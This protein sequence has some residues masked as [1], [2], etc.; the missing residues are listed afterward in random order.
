[1]SG[2]FNDSKTFVDMPLKQEPNVILSK[3]STLLSNT[4]ANGG[5]SK[6][7]LSNFLDEY[8]YPAGYEVQQVQPVDWVPNPP[9]IHEL[10]D[11]RL[12]H[13]AKSIHDKWL[14]LARIF[15][16]S[17][18]CDDCYSS[19]SVP[20][21]F[22]IAGSRFREFYYWDSYWILRGLLV[23]DMTLTARG[24]I[25]NMLGLV[26]KYGFMPN[27]G[28]IYYL[29]RSQPPLLVQMVLEFWEATKDVEFLREV[30][31]I[32]DSE[33]QWWMQNRSVSI[34]NPNQPTTTYT[35][36]RY[37]VDN[38]GPRPES[39][40]EDYSMAQSAFP[41][42]TAEQIF[43]Y[44]SIAS[45][46]ES[47]MD[48]STRWFKP[49]S[50][51]LSTIE[52][53]DIVPVCLNSILFRNE[54]VLEEFH[55][56]L[57]NKEQS[58]YYRK[59]AVLRA[60]ALEVLFWDESTL[61]FLDYHIPSQSLTPPRFYP[62]NF[63][64]FYSKMLNHSSFSMNTNQID[65]MLQS[66]YPVVMGFVG[67]VPTSSIPSGQQWDFPNAWPPHQYFIIETLVNLN[68]EMSSSMSQDL[69]NRWVLTSYC[70]W[71]S[72]LNT[73][74]GMMFE[75]YNVTNIGVPGGGGEY[76]VQDGFG[77]S[78]G[79]GPKSSIE[80]AKELNVDSGY[81]Y[82]ILRV[83]SSTLPY[84]VFIEGENQ[85]FS[86]NPQC[87]QDI[88]KYQNLI[89]LKAACDMYNDVIYK[90]LGEALEKGGSDYPIAFENRPDSIKSFYEYIDKT[91][92]FS[93]IFHPTM[94]SLN[95]F[96]FQ[97]ILQ[98]IDFN[99]FGTI[100]DIGGSQGHLLLKILE[101][102]KSVEKGINFDT[103]TTVEN[104]KQ[105]VAQR[106]VFPQHVLAKFEEI[107]GSFFEKVPSGGDLYIFR[108]I[109]HN[110]YDHQAEKIIEN[111]SWAMK[112][113]SK[114]YIIESIVNSKNVPN[115]SVYLDIVMMTI[116]GG[117][118]RTIKEFS[119]LGSKFGL[120]LENNLELS[121]GTTCII[122][123]K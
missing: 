12:R 46:A 45:A 74:G 78:N 16:H 43:F 88:F 85:V 31:P 87:L 104:N 29:N 116:V 44:E 111:V 96:H 5:P 68:T 53:V 2:I 19:T 91:P 21:P 119:N 1:M 26:Q 114:I 54:K 95:A 37:N 105:F 6:I 33:Y 107:G 62:T 118:E 8:F 64:P 55:H 89:Q 77:W 99:Q 75:K 35:L 38:Q 9:F 20:N 36:N 83:L 70:G 122:L 93:S 28:R 108:N 10:K 50:Y 71:Y 39:Y 81:L 69:I 22:I 120:K 48:F 103:P 86:L 13:F 49:G 67:G 82:R 80:I 113:T 106:N 23:S 112:P 98:E 110:W 121:S 11:K 76:V 59:Q 58:T 65:Q 47:G 90:K 102:N 52:T 100:F 17:E 94:E 97:S 4:S 123:S 15:N 109:F 56:I 61:Q 42:N 40:Y 18:L 32:L 7:Q 92:S 60:E 25:M 41:N 117:K 84:G 57:G 72:T 34:P 51:N 101:K 66:I 30:L 14:G 24:M 79:N 63:L 27:G 3:F 73:D 115:E